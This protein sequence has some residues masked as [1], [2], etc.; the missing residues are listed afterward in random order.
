VNQPVDLQSAALYEEFTRRLLL[1]T[2][3]GSARPQWK[4]ESFFRRYGGD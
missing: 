4:A 2:A 1:E 3:N